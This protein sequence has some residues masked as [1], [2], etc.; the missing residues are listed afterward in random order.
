MALK[1]QVWEIGRHM[2]YSCHH[3]LSHFIFPIFVHLKHFSV[4]PSLQSITPCIY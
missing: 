2:T 3:N 4:F 1:S